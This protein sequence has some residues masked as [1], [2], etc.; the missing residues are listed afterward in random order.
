MK[1]ALGSDHAGFELKQA[2]L[3]FLAEH[4]IE[5]RDYGAF[6]QERVDYPDFSAQVA[7]AVAD[8][9]FDRGILI[10]HSGIGMSITA[11]KVKGVRAALCTDA[12]C[13]KLSREHNDAN[14]LVLGQRMTSPE[15]ALE[16]VDTWLRSNFSGE[17]R[18]ARRIRKVSEME[19]Q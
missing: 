4:G 1:V 2:V 13:A 19:S 14:V 10:C 18:H 7:R 15:E 8:G 6:S 16:I 9:E 17:E 3:G 11:N 12:A 5:A